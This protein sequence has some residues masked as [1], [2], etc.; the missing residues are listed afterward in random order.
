MK[1]FVLLLCAAGA[2]AATDGTCEEPGQ[3]GDAGG[4]DEAHDICV[5]GAG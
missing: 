2:A 1:A 4:H 3:C 5:V